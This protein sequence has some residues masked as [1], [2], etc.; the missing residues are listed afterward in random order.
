MLRDIKV[1]L[2]S[3]WGVANAEI[4]PFDWR[5]AT[6]VLETALKNY[7]AAAGTKFSFEPA[8]SA[9]AQLSGGLEKF[10]V[11]VKSGAVPAAVANKA[12]KRLARILVP[13]EQSR[14][15]RFAHDPAL[16]RPIIPLLSLA[17]SLAALSDSDLKFAKVDLTRNQNRVVEL[18][19][20]ATE[21]ITAS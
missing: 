20:S 15:W 19:Q 9:L 10:Y 1:Y 18:L 5:A 12:I 4:L 6:P 8:I 11:A 3:V 16:P 14:E 7:Q 13:L 2:A 17:S 21:L